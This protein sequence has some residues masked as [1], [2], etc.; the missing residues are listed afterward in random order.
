[1]TETAPA[2]P[3]STAINQVPKAQA[4]QN[5]DSTSLRALCATLHARITAFLQEDVPTERLKA[6]QAQTR[7]SLAIIQE[8]LDRY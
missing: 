6:V 1:M 8:A 4:L 7:K 3:L 2:D 5:G